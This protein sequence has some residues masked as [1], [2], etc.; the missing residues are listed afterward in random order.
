MRKSTL[1][2]LPFIFLCLLFA[3]GSMA[4]DKRSIKDSSN[5]G[6][7]KFKLNSNDTIAHVKNHIQWEGDRSINPAEKK[8]KKL[9]KK[10]SLAGKNADDAK[11]SPHGHVSW[12]GDKSVAKMAKTSND[13]MKPADKIQY[14]LKDTLRHAKNHTLW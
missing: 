2:S 8:Y 12:S 5:K 3:E 1:K 13:T 11:Q 14:Q 9:D 4:Q 6:V 7:S 10:I